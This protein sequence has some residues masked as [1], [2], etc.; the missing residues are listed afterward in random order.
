MRY[1]VTDEFY[2][3]FGFK[4]RA[5]LPDIGGIDADGDNSADI[6]DNL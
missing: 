6:S 2:R 1:D 4:S 3:L 5:D